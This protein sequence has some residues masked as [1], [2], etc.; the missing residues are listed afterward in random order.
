MGIGSSFKK[1]VGS[2]VSKLPGGDTRLGGAI[3]GA[4]LG[5]LA[6]PLGTLGGAT[7]GYMAGKY[8]SE[9]KKPDGTPMTPEEIQAITNNSLF[10]RLSSTEQKDLLLNNP[11]IMTP[12][13]SQIYDPYTNT[14]S[15]NESDFTKNQR[16][17]QE[18]LADQLA[19]SLSGELPSADNELARQTTYDL[20]LKQLQPQLKSQRESLATQL[21][22]QGIPINSEAYNSA[23]N[24][25]DKAQGDQLNELSMQSVLQGIQIGEAQR[26]ARFNEI[27]S[28]LGRTQVGAGANFGM[29][30]PSYQGLDLMGA[31]QA[32]LNRQASMDM[33]RMQTKAATSAAKWQAGGQVIGA[34][35]GAIG[36]Y[37]SSRK[38]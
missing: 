23:M 7:G 16:L 33:A 38:K 27:S 18:K 1:A 35:I 26:Q 17:Q 32:N 31:E 28:L 3:Y 22:N 24:R 19:M 12:E 29:F 13:G 20:G 21:A 34:G 11:N 4:A 14:V 2:V 5:S 15:I 10:S 8:G 36:D 37:Y 30:Q 9:Y 6:G 25:L